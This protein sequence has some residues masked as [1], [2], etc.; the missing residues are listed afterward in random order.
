M[1]IVYLP[2]FIK[3]IDYKLL[4]W[5]DKN[6]GSSEIG[7]EMLDH[8]NLGLVKLHHCIKRLVKEG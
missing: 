2:K 7:F 6:G 8:M 1:P 4:L 3:D 5:L